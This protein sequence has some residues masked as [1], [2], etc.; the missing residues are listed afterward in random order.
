MA[1]VNPVRKPA[2]SPGAVPRTAGGI[3]DD[4]L[5]GSVR[6]IPVIRFN[7]R[8]LRG[9]VY[10]LVV[11]LRADKNSPDGAGISGGTVTVHPIVP[12]ALVTPQWQEMSTAAGS[13]ARFYV[14]PVAI[15]KLREARVEFRSGNRILETVPLV[16]GLDWIILLVSLILTGPI[17]PVLYLLSFSRYPKVRRGYWVWFFVALTVALPTLLYFAKLYQWQPSVQLYIDKPAVSQPAEQGPQGP[18]A[19]GEQ[20]GPRG[21]G[22]GIRNRGQPGGEP[23]S[24]ADDPASK[25]PAEKAPPADKAN[26]P[27]GESKPPE[28][29]PDEAKKEEP[30]SEEPKK[31]EEP[32][33]EDSP[34]PPEKETGEKSPD[35][36]EPKPENQPDKDELSQTLSALAAGTT[37]GF[38]PPDAEK[39]PPS[40]APGGPPRGGPGGPGSGRPGGFGPGGPGGPGGPPRGGPGGPGGPGGGPPPLGMPA[41]PPPPADGGKERPKMTYFGEDAIRRGLEHQEKI[42]DGMSW[43]SLDTRD[44]LILGVCSVKDYI[45]VCYRNCY[46]LPRS[47]QYS[48]LVLFAILAVI[49]AVYAVAFGSVRTR[50][51]GRVFEVPA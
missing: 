39:T 27:A 41:L 7:A 38:Q 28:S 3:A 48:E 33:K 36:P 44:I 25:A 4:G 15:G 9:R 40:K 42:R 18:A 5:R 29:K 21:A 10:P 14:T 16:R 47:M 20:P 32:K 2:D 30:K 26:E 37:V 6:R 45:L 23:A 8:M 51:T 1:T 24:K 46:E 22:A 11:Q 50:K 49:T 12:G 35:K 17:I 34:K 13:E 19:S 43:D 31:P